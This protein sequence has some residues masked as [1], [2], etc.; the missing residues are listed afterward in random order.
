MLLIED[1]IFHILNRVSSINDRSCLFPGVLC[2]RVLGEGH[3]HHMPE[4]H[5]LIALRPC[6]PHTQAELPG[7]RTAWVCCFP[8]GARALSRPTSDL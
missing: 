2:M 7:H 6:S 1:T 3:A 5:R 4:Q 8:E